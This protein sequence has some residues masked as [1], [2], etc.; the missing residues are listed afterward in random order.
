MSKEACIPTLHEV[1]LA[2]N[3]SSIW[4]LF[5]SLSEEVEAALSSLISLGLFLFEHFEL[6]L[7]HFLNEVA[8]LFF[9]YEI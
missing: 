1:A 7:F 6:C 8:I 4:R 3:C 9:L 5:M 2:H